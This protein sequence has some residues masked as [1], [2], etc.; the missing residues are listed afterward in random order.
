MKNSQ[1][2]FIYTSFT[3]LGISNINKPWLHFGTSSM[4]KRQSLGLKRILHLAWKMLSKERSDFVM[5][6]IQGMY[7]EYLLVKR[8]V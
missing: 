6:R 5:I 8:F 4:K 2:D 3:L 1:G 7:A